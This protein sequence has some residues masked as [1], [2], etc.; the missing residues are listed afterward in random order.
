MDGIIM[1]QKFNFEKYGE[2]VTSLE[3]DWFS[4]YLF[5]SLADGSIYKYTL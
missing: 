5:A 4:N 1:D 2:C 3:I